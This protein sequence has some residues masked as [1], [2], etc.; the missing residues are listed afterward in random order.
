LT[1]PEVDTTTF[2]E[3]VK[4]ARRTLAQL[5]E[6]FKNSDNYVPNRLAE[7]SQDVFLVGEDNIDKASIESAV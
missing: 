4:S 5:W 6:D 1:L 7:S 3:S 2:E